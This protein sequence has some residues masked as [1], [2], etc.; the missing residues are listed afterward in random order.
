[1]Q[2]GRKKAKELLEEPGVDLRKL[3]GKLGKLWSWQ[4]CQAG[5]REV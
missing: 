5:K 3:R 4:E 1:M 2:S